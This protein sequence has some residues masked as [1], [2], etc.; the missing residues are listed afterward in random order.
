V[1]FRFSDLIVISHFSSVG[2]VFVGTTPSK[3]P[4]VGP[5][6]GGTE[7]PSIYP[8]SIPSGIVF[9]LCVSLLPRCT[10]NSGSHET[11]HPETDLRAGTCH[12]QY[13]STSRFCLH[14]LIIAVV[15]SARRTAGTAP[16]A[17]GRTVTGAGAGA[18]AAGATGQAA[19]LAREL[20]LDAHLV[21]AVLSNILDSGPGVGWDDIGARLCLCCRHEPFW[22]NALA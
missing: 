17:A 21:E 20:G 13:G 16:A 9:L 6:G 4:I 12:S 7:P 11:N 10:A 5:T 2:C 14:A 3:R 18:G 15:V 22:S 8:M 1:V 19:Q